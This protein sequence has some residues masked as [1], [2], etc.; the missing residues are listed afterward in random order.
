MACVALPS[1][2]MSGSRGTGLGDVLGSLP[3]ALAARGHDVMVV[4]PLYGSSKLPP[5]ENLGAQV[6]GVKYED[7]VAA[8]VADLRR[9]PEAVAEV[10]AGMEPVRALALHDRGLDRIDQRSAKAIG[11]RRD[12]GGVDEIAI[13]TVREPVAP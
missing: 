4:T 10:L 7:E 5:L 2:I 3:A 8:I 12:R 11:P 1:G 6:R 13:R 9:L